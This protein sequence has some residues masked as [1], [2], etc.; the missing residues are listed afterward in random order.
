MDESEE[1]IYYVENPNDLI[2]FDDLFDS[3]DE[4]TDE[5]DEHMSFKPMSLGIDIGGTVEFQIG[6]NISLDGEKDGKLEKLMTKGKNI[7]K[8]LK[9]EASVVIKP[10][11]TIEFIYDLNIF[12]EDYMY[13]KCAVGFGFELKGS[14]GVKVGTLPENSKAEP[15]DMTIPI[16]KIYIP[17]GIPGL[18]ADIDFEIPF[19]WELSG[20]MNFQ[21]KS[22]VECGTIYTS[23]TGH[24]QPINKADSTINFNITSDYRFTWGPKFKTGISFLGEVIKVNLEVHFGMELSGTASSK[25]LHWDILSN[26]RHECGLC[27]NADIYFF[28][29]AKLNGT[30]GWAKLSVTIA[31]W[32]F[33]IGNAYLSWINDRESVLKGNPAFG[34]YL[35]IGSIFSVILDIPGGLPDGPSLGICPNYTYKETFDPQDSQGFTLSNAKITAKRISD[36]LTYSGTGK[37]FEYMYPGVYLVSV[38]ESNN[39]FTDEII[40]VDNLIDATRT[41]VLRS[42]LT[43][44]EKLSINDPGIKTYGDE[45]FTLS[46]TGGSGDGAVTYELLSG[47]NVIS[48]SGN[49]VMIRNSGTAVVVATKVGSDGYA[50]ATSERFTIT[51]NKRSL[52]TVTVIVNE[53]YTYNG[54]THL[55]IPVAT[56]IGTV[57]TANDY[58]ISYENNKNAGLASVIITATENGNYL[59]SKNG[60]FVIDKSILTVKANDIAISFGDIIPYY[61]Y[62]LTGFTPNEDDSVV[63]GTPTFICDY[64]KDNPRGLYELKITQ[65]T[66]TA[67][68]YDFNFANGTV[69]VEMANQAPLTIQGGNITKT[70]SDES[71]NVSAVG[72]TGNGAVTYDIITGANV[73][74]DINRNT[75]EVIILGAGEATIVA[76]KSGDDD[77]RPIS[78]EPITITVG[79]RN[80]SNVETGVNG[81]FT[82]NG[83]EHK[84]TPFVN[85]RSLITNSDYAISYTNNKNAGIAT[86]TITATADGN[87]TG[88]RIIEFIINKRDLSLVT[89]NVNVTFEYDG[90]FHEPV[91]YI[92][93]GDSI[94][95]SDYTVSHD[96]NINAGNATATIIATSDGNYTGLKPVNFTIGQRNLSNVTVTVN[97]TFTYN[98]NAYNPIPTVSDGGIPISALD[99]TVSHSYNIHASDTAMLTI[100]ATANGNYTLSKSAFFTINKAA[101]EAVSGIMSVQSFGNKSIT[102][103]P[104]TTTTGQKVEYAISTTVTEPADSYWVEGQTTFSA[105]ENKTYYVFART[106]ENGNYTKGLY[107]MLTIPNTGWTATNTI[108]TTNEARTYGFYFIV[109]VEGTWRILDTIKSDGMIEEKTHYGNCN[110]DKNFAPW[111]IEEVG[112][113]W[114]TNSNGLFARKYEFE[115][116]TF[117]MNYSGTTMFSKTWTKFT[118]NTSTMRYPGSS[119]RGTVEKYFK[120][121]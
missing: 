121:W 29:R 51:V 15:V 90:T 62:T 21:I 46:T 56:D 39:Y 22:D 64:E 2:D 99:Y 53:S 20:T 115:Y 119:G 26:Y 91:P 69:S 25:S 30:I 3:V 109:K 13:F 55:P 31:E 50:P 100:I 17:L 40:V 45:S 113:R 18:F 11:A 102:V 33:Y 57:I 68:N 116:F 70:Y 75:G 74:V 8:N 16:A 37:F 54:R 103:A 32:R 87:Y 92:D 5:D 104:V 66:L 63:I 43:Y 107:S 95:T 23:N 44:Q 19:E 96:N 112:L 1:G 88:E 34:L 101:G 71:F 60:N 105:T 93:E 81:T 110:G 9:I 114:D 79:K 48:L 120:M 111:L 28:V 98:G 118:D 10:R 35:R 49:T 47:S 117:A 67:D 89:A 52:S 82:Y 83:N 85:D 58:I 41:V 78:S 24:F 84:P 36:G 61:T 14:A 108:K 106:K 77:H 59:G 94:S 27:L 6:F 65:G 73:V 12:S 76:R 97:G 4:F 80:I 38:T 42:N 7:A 86:L 72:G